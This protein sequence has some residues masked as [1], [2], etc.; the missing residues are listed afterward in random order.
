VTG[1]AGPTGG[2][3]EKPVGLVYIVRADR[4]GAE[5]REC[6]FTGGRDRIRARSALTAL[7]MVRRWAIG[8]PGG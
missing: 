3:P 1:I 2:T 7:D 5:A 8:Q 6:R 4:Q